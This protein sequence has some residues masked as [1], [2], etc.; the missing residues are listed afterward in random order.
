[1]TVIWSSVG[2]SSGISTSGLSGLVAGGAGSL[3][4]VVGNGRS[5]VVARH[6]RVGG[7][8]VAGSVTAAAARCEEQSGTEEEW[9][10]PAHRSDATCEPGHPHVTPPN[11]YPTPTPHH[12]TPTPTRIAGS[13]R[14]RGGGGGDPGGFGASE[15]GGRVGVDEGPQLGS[16][17]SIVAAGAEFAEQR[18]EPEVD[19][20]D[21]DERSWHGRVLADGARSIERVADD[22]VRVLTGPRHLCVGPH[23]VVEV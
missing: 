17:T 5:G 6:G 19:P 12:P 11:P 3:E 18:V 14:L 20:L 15:V 4:S 7:G 23:G 13:R 21:E 8:L 10:C 1:M 9:E 16:D 2:I 22:R